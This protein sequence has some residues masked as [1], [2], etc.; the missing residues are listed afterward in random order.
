MSWKL[1]LGLGGVA[2]FAW[3]YA[4]RKTE[5]V[6]AVRVVEKGVAPFEPRFLG[7]PLRMVK[8]QRYRF[9]F[10]SDLVGDF[11]SGFIGVKIYAYAEE[12]PP[13][14]PAEVKSQGDPET[15]WGVGVWSAPSGLLDRPR[16]LWQIWVTMSNA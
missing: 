11:L 14:W 7:N 8:G 9:R 13:D 12:L 6:T 15:R 3:A 10:R 5:P 4:T 1:W 2:V 16:G